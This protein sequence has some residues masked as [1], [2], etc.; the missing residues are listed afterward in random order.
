MP[1]AVGGWQGHY[2]GKGVVL[3]QACTVVCRL[4]FTECVVRAL[5]HAACPSWLLRCLK[6]NNC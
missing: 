1:Q 3:W 6:R 4:L 2:M 5:L